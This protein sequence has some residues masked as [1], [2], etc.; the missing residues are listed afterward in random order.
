MTS[1]LPAAALQA[2]KAALNAAMAENQIKTPP[3]NGDVEDGEIQEV[4]MEAQAENIRTVFSDPKNFNVKVRLAYSSRT[5][6]DCLP[7]SSRA[8]YSTRCI[9]HGLSGLIHLQLRAGISHKHPCHRSP[10]RHC[11]RPPAGSLRKAGWRI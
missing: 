4:N 8:L 7:E 2:S 5:D 11:H 9:H 3:A 10:K 1:T 6:H